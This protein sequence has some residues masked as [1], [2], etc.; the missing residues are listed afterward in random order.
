M[1]IP[2]VP[3]GYCDVAYADTVNTATAWTG[4]TTTVKENAIGYT[5]VYFDSIYSCIW[6]SDDGVPDVIQTANAVLAEQY[7]IDSTQFFE[8]NTKT[9]LTGTEGAAGSV[10]TKK[11]FDPIHAND[12]VDKFPFITGLVGEYCTIPSSQVSSMAIV[13]R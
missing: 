8:V 5:R 2:G 4:A 6:D 12:F 11:T 13:R 9:G 7:V 10:K 3:D 1:S